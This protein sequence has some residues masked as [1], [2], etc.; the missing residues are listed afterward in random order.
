[1]TTQVARFAGIAG[2]LRYAAR[3]LRRQPRHA[4][5]TILTMALGIGATAV[6]FSV[7][8]GVLLKPLPWPNAERLVVLKETRGGSP[9]RF[10]DFTNAA[11]LAWRGEAST[12]EDL[13]AWSQRL[14]TLTGAGDPERI[15]ITTATASLFP[16]LGVRPLIGSFFDASDETSP[17]VVLSEGLWRQRFSADPAVLGRHLDLDGESYTIVGVLPDTA[18]YPNRQARAVIP[19]SVRPTAD[20]HLSLFS[21]IA[22]LRPGITPAQAIAEGTARGRFAA[23]TGMTTTA[24]FGS[25]GPVAIGA[26][27]LREALT[28]GVRRPLI[29]LLVAVGLLLATAIA[30]VASLQLAR[31]T[32]RA[33]EM[34]I[35]A[36]LGAGGARVTRQLLVESLLLGLMGGAA[37]ISC[38]L[39]LHSVLR[40][41]L[42]ADFPRLDDVGVDVVVLGFALAIS[43]ASSVVFGLLPVWHV[44]RLNLVETLAEG[45]T[46]PVGAG[47]RTRTARARRLIMSAQVAIACVLLVGA[48]LLGR[49][50]MALLTTDRGFDPAA[51]LSARLALPAAIY[52]TEQQRFAIIDELLD[53]LAR[54]P[55]VTES[56]F[57]S[58]LPLTP[59]GSTSAFSLKSAGAGG[60]TVRVQASPRI[61]SQRYFSA[62]RINIV[63]GRGFS[64]LDTESSEPVVVVNQAFARRYLGEDPI[65]AR[66]PTGAYA[67]P[68]EQ[69]REWTIIGVAEDVR[70]VTGTDISQPEMYYSYRQMGGRL[71]VQTVT[72]LARTAGAPGAAA[73]ALAAA[74]RETDARLVADVVLP[75]G[76]R[77]LTSLAQ[78]RLYAV[79]LGAFA[80][81]ALVIAAVGLYGVLS[82]SVSQRARELAIRAALGAGRGEIV[83][84]V[85]RQ[86]LSV[87]VGGI[88]AGMVAATWLTRVLSTQLYGVTTHDPLTFVLVPLLLLTVGTLACVLPARRAASL[89]PLRT[90]RGG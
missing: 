8:Y 84:L 56:A 80:S 34:A 17:V 11:Y 74:V 81:C 77:L 25:N 89:D 9:P 39:V 83:R 1:V 36:A 71:P 61:V 22:L 30:N 85:V 14:V 68:D 18:A 24:I 59:G 87:T 27:T 15:R 52:R 63:A 76:Q 67:P 10:G 32:A 35:R 46:A 3:L 6:L 26:Q 66:L 41:V 13:A 69:S 2:D 29:V 28:T 43:L 64:D 73:M 7:T 23:D 62:L 45:G 19:F 16:V 65:G 82:Y 47:V 42:P 5:L 86:G 75:L 51:V 20:N 54:I 37:G 48:S 40:S 79:L 33:R 38:T 53:R 60:A 44:R 58:E 72:L 78:P 57:T 49:S 50:F 4:L 90:L 70:Y 88:A 31:T 55:A 12:V 21:A